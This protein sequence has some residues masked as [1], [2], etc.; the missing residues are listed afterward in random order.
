[1]GQMVARNTKPELES[2]FF[3]LDRRLWEG[4]LC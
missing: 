1:M 2:L 4:A 3:W